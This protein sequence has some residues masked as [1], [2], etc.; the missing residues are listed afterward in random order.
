MT[1]IVNKAAK[2][3]ASSTIVMLLPVLLLA[4][5]KGR[6]LD[7]AQQEA[8]EAKAT[9]NKLN[10]SLKT[11]AEEIATAKAELDAVRQGR[12]ETQKRMEQLIRERDQASTSAQHAQETVTRLTTQASG[13]DSMTVALQKQVAELKTL[14]EE[15]QKLID[16]LPKS[17]PAQPG[18]QAVDKQATSDPNQMP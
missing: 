1:A 11:A 10:Y 14:V 7:E 16:Q 4:G 3:A 18:A 9:I 2:T 12:D 17:A 6:A 5:C 15:Q 8:R 13:Q